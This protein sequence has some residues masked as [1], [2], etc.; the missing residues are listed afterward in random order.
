MFFNILLINLFLIIFLLATIGYGKF[1]NIL[2]FKTTYK[3]NYGECGLLGIVFISFL[4]TFIHFFYK[5][6]ENINSIIYFFGLFLAFNYFSKIKVFLKENKIL[7]STL[8]ITAFLMVIY[9]KPNEDFGYYHLPYLINFISD[10]VIF[11][12]ASVQTN[13]GWN[14]MWLNLTATYNLPII[15]MN[16]IHLTNVV[17]F[18]FFSLAIL[19]PIINFR[20]NKKKNYINFLTVLYCLTFFLYFILK[21]SRLGKY[22]FDVP[23]N[24]IAIYCFYLF[25][26]FF[27]F[28]NE[29]TNVKNNIFQ[30][31]I[32]FSLFSVLIKLS[33]LLILLIPAFIFFKNDVKIFSKTFT[34]SCFFFLVWVIQQFVY[35]GCFVFPLILSCFDVSW[36]NL[37]PVL[38]LLNHTKGINK[39]FAQ[40]QGVLSEL[41]YSRNYNWVP[42]WFGRNKIEMLEHLSTFL[43][44]FSFLIIF[45]YKKEI[46]KYQ[47]N[48]EHLYNILIKQ[49]VLCRISSIHACIN[50]K[51]KIIDNDKIIYVSIFIFQTGNIIIIGK[52]PEYIRN[53]YIFIVKLLNKYKPIIMKRNICELI[54]ENYIKNFLE[55][56]K[57]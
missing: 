30:K 25:L 56:I 19:D 47:I 35:T 34:L 32:I 27:F 11:G 50:I 38:D 7:I 40:Y 54:D 16:G 45:F 39:S 33:N 22:G 49:N 15:G 13:Q 17:F 1:L 9:H 23:S 46:I 55:N 52:K 37:D 24:F 14:S 20:Y 3:S 10:K 8:F 29:S 6:D 21:F 28:K 43:L 36:F 48:K 42:T 5:I 31:I 57:V 12:L 26:D 18:I 2:L 51:H 53:A 41:E 44:I 4:S